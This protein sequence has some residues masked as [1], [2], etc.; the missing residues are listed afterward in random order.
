M[1]LANHLSSGSGVPFAACPARVGRAPEFCSGQYLPQ[2]SPPRRRTLWRVSR[3][4]GSNSLQVLCFLLLSCLEPDFFLLHFHQTF[5]YLAILILLFCME[6]RW[7]YRI[8]IVAPAAWLVMTFA[9][10]SLAERPP[11]WYVW[12]MVKD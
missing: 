12:A 5:V 4:H 10:G 3:D 2:A 8:G 9:S 7:A 1:F 11:S 6:D